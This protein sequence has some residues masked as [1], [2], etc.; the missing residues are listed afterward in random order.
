M[1]RC[2]APN[3]SLTGR[4]PRVLSRAPKRHRSGRIDVEHRRSEPATQGAVELEPT[5]HP[6]AVEQ[7]EG[8]TMERVKHIAHFVLGHGGNDA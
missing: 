4:A 1:W 8:I 6:L 3:T 5:D 7:R 2:F